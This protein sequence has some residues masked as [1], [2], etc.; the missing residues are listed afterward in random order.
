[1]VVIWGV[2]DNMGKRLWQIVISIFV[3]T[4]VLVAPACAQTVIDCANYEREIIERF[5]SGTFKAGNEIHAGIQKNKFEVSDFIDFST[6]DGVQSTVCTKKKTQREGCWGVPFEAT[7]YENNVVI[8]RGD[9]YDWL[10]LHHDFPATPN[11]MSPGM[12]KSQV[13]D[14]LGRA[15]WERENFLQYIMP[16]TDDYGLGL[17]FDTAIDF[18]F[19]DDGLALISFVDVKDECVE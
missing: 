11:G 8:E 12:S 5:K 18:Y 14:I 15:H 6:L 4:V 10:L 16:Q 9:P 17:T 1:M 7:I 13:K 3:L 2:I 19:I